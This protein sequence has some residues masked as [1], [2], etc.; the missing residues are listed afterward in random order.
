MFASFL[1]IPIVLSIFA[2]SAGAR[3]ATT[4]GTR[5]INGPTRTTLEQRR[6]TVAARIS[7][8]RKERIR[9]FWGRMITR[10]EAAIARLERLVE[11]MEKRI[12]VIKAEDS[13]LDVDSAEKDI[14]QAKSLLAEAKTNLASL[15]SDFEE[16]LSSQEPK[17]A[18]K[19]ISD[20]IRTIKKDLVEI[21]R[22]LVHAI[23]EIKGLRVSEGT[24]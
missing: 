12:A 23:G 6:A 20:E 19:S 3:I 1:A 5:D 22:L 18:F 17:E 16:M 21:H 10:I 8:I 15:K 11:R 7:L 13:T 24:Q 4:T 14:S 2:P 9:S